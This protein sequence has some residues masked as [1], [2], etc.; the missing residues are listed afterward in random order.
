MKKIL[1]AVV[2]TAAIMTLIFAG[3][4]GFSIGAYCV[5]FGLERDADGPPKA[6]ALIMPPYA[7]SFT[8]PDAP[9]ETWRIKSFDGLNLVATH[10]SPPT[11]SDDWIIV[12]HGYGCTQQ[13][14]WYIA[15][16]YLDMGYH[17]LTPDLRAS[18]LSEGSFITLGVKESIDI[19]DWARETAKRYPH[20]KI[21][22][23]G[24]SMG[25]AT[26]MMTAARDDLPE[27]LV[28]VIEE[29][30]FSSAYDLLAIKLEN[31]FDIPAYPIMPIVDYRC[32]NLAD[33]SLQDAAPAKSLTRAK[34]PVL[35]IH[36][37]KDVIVPPYM[38]DILY[39]ACRAPQKDL[40]VAKGGTHGAASQTN[41]DE[42]FNRA[43]KFLRPLMNN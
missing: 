6:F 8:K 22:L 12:I 18:G 25:A 30:G 14:S 16:V 10:F 19:A 41:R 21:A 2:L 43:E 36:G 3:A 13:N 42:Y 5:R 40:F 1:S 7:R 38:A 11:P 27:N 39:R 20:A 23:H 34:L 29:C 9:N 15:S 33:F 28:A 32:E 26:A 31:S 37:D 24:I 4:A 35:F 17:V